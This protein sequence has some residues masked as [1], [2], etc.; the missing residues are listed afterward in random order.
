[1]QHRA[2]LSVWQQ[3]GVHVQRHCVMVFKMVCKGCTGGASLQTSCP[4]VL[5]MVITVLLLLLLTGCLQRTRQAQCCTGSGEKWG[6][7]SS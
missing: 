4:A 7:R 2:L 5:Q 6:G 3:L 1:V